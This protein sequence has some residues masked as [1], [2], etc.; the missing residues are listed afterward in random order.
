[1][2][3]FYVLTP[4]TTVAVCRNPHCSQRSEAASEEV[5]V[6]DAGFT[7]P[8]MSGAVLGAQPSI[9]DAVRRAGPPEGGQNTL[10]TRSDA[11]LLNVHSSGTVGSGVLQPLGL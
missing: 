8:R 1:M 4:W 11:E 3:R 5:P 9:T 2:G 10:D 7:H 6:C